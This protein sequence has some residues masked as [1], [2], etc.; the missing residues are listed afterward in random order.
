MTR[1]KF[2][3]TLERLAAHMQQ[4][5]TQF[6]RAEGVQSPDWVDFCRC[7]SVDLATLNKEILFFAA[8]R[9]PAELLEDA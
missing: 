5:A 6:L 2:D 9:W 7:T 1:E 8:N 3:D 4:A